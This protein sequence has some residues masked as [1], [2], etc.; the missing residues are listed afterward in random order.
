MPSI[1]PIGPI[2]PLPS[3][4]YPPSTIYYFTF[5]EVAFPSRPFSVTLRDSILFCGTLATSPHLPN[6]TPASHFKN[7]SSC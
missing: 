3:I 2:L 5:P 7:P 4:D 1:F 6:P